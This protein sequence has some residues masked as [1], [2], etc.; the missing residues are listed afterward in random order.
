MATVKGDV[1]DIGKNIVGVVL[2]CNNYEV[3]RSR[4]DG[5]GGEDPADA[6]IEQQGR[7]HRPERP[8]HAVARRDGVRRAGD[9]APRHS[10][11]PLL[12]GGATTSR[13]HT[14]VK[15]APEYSGPVVHVLDASR[16]VDVV[17]SLLE[18]RRG[19]AFDA[20]NRV[21]QAELREQLRD[22]PREA[23]ADLRRRRAPTGCGS[24]GTT[25]V[26]ADAV[27][28]SGAAYLDDVPLDELVPYI[29]WT[30][31]F[32]AW[33]LKG[34]FP[35]DPRSSAVRRGGARAVRQ[36]AGA[37]RSRSSTSKLLTR[38]RRLRVLAGRTATATTSSSTRTT[39]AAASSTRL[40]MLRQQE[41][42]ADGRPNRSLADFIAPRETRRARLHRR[43]RG[44]RGPRRRRAG[45]ALRARTTTTTTRSW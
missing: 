16:V 30:F 40:P 33:E 7:H 13:Q 22:A 12:I 32:S 4:R 35:G 8:D 3:D 5:A 26:I 17:S 29:D 28:S 1:H 44:D 9:G 21:A 11:L 45:A 34:R 19:A 2:G 27:R 6:A 23:A 18:R 37:A 31:F 14:A 43:V 42:I 38:A 20:A 24:T 25:D 39:R 36:R 15:I 10:R 41:A